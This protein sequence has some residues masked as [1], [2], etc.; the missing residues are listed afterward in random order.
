M[1]RIYYCVVI[2]WKFINHNLIF[3]FKQIFLME[4]IVLYLDYSNTNPA[5][6]VMIDIKVSRYDLFFANQHN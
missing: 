5:F 6:F 3:K 1:M 4:Y 2:L